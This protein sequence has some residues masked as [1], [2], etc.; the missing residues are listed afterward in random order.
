MSS[1]PHE[2]RLRTFIAA[3][4]ALAIALI[5]PGAV[6]AQ[7]CPNP[8]TINSA[9]IEFVDAAS[10]A[11][12]LEGKGV[13]STA[14]GTVLRGKDMVTVELDYFQP[15][16]SVRAV[17]CPNPR[18]EGTE[19]IPNAARGV[20]RLL[21]ERASEPP[22]PPAPR[23]EGVIREFL[24]V[25][26]IYQGG[27]LVGETTVLVTLEA[28][29]VDAEGQPISF[30]D[31]AV[32]DRIVAEG[33]RLD[34]VAESPF[35]GIAT[36]E[37]DFVKRLS[38]VPPPPPPPVEKR[39]TIVEIAEGGCFALTGEF[40]DD[41]TKVC[42]SNTTVIRTVDGVPLGFGDLAVEDFVTVAGV[43]TED[44]VLAAR[45]VIRAEREPQEIVVE[46]PIEGI[47]EAG[48]PWIGTL[49]VEGRTILVSEG[50]EIREREGA[51]LT[52]ADLGEGDMV[53][54][55]A[56]RLPN[57]PP[58]S[59]EEPT[60]EIA[61]PNELFAATSIVRLGEVPPTPT[62]TPTPVPTE[63]VTPTPTRTPQPPEALTG[64]LREIDAESRCFT[65]VTDRITVVQ[66]TRVCTT[67]TTQFIGADETAIRF[68]DLNEGD[69]V[70]VSLVPSPDNSTPA[71]AAVVRVVDPN[72][73]RVEVRGP[74]RSIEPGPTGS[75]GVV[76]VRETPFI[77][78][79]AT[80]LID[81]EGEPIRFEQLAV[82][83]FV[84]AVGSRTFTDVAVVAEKIRLLPDPEVVPVTLR[85][86]IEEVSVERS[87]LIVRGTLVTVGPDTRILERENEALTL[88]D[89]AT[90]DQVIVEGVRAS[91]NTVAAKTI[92]R[93]NPVVEEPVVRFSDKIT[94][95]D[96]E[97]AVLVVGAR[98]VQ[99]NGE[100]EILNRAGEAMEFADLEV[101]QLVAVV[102]TPLQGAE[103]G[104]P[105]VVLASSIRIVAP[106]C[107]EFRIAGILNEKTEDAWL[108]GDKRVRITEDTTFSAGE[109]IRLNADDFEI[110][111]RVVAFGC[112]TPGEIP[113][114][115]HIVLQNPNP[116]PEPTVCESTVAFAGPVESIDV[117]AASLVVGERT[118]QVNDDTI[119]TK[120]ED[121][122]IRL[123]DIPVGA[124]AFVEGNP[125]ED[126]VVA[127][128][129][130][131]EDR[132][133]P[134]RPEEHRIVGRIDTI[135]T[136]SLTLTVRDFTI[137]VT[138]ETRIVSRSNDEL[139]FGDLS[140]GMLIDAKGRLFPDRMLV[141]GIIRVQEENTT[142][143]PMRPFVGE[144]EEIALPESLVVR[145]ITVNLTNETRFRGF[146][147]EVL[148]PTTLVIGD[149]VMVFPVVPGLDR[150][151]RI[152]TA[153]AIALR[154]VIIEAI[155]AENRWITV[156]GSPVAVV[157]ETEIVD[158][159]SGPITFED[160]AVGDVVRV[161]KFDTE[162]FP[163]HASHILRV[164]G[165][166]FSDPVGDMDGVDGDVEDGRPTFG[167]DRPGN[168]F[169]FVSLPLDMG[170]AEPNTLYEILMNV[171]TNITDPLRI[172]AA[173]VRVNMRN[174][175]KGATAVV[176]S[177]A[178]FSHVPDTR[179]RTYSLLFVPPAEIISDDPED[180]HFFVSLDMLNF[181][182]R[183]A[184]GARFRLESV[185]VDPIDNSRISV[186]ETLAEDTFVS[187]TEGWELGGVDGVFTLPEYGA[188]SGALTLSAR[189]RSTFGYWTKDTGATAEPGK[190]YRARFL[191]H[192][193]LDDAA[194]LPT[195]RLRLN[196]SS[197]ELGSTVN[198][199]PAGP[200][201]ET[202]STDPRVYDVYMVIPANDPGTATIRAS[203]DI[204]CF[205]P[206]NSTDA[207]ITIERFILEEVEI[208]D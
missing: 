65:V 76:T 122:R 182:D 189:D 186:V 187:G 46:G 16:M 202:L 17:F 208:T 57:P 73:G 109:D 13:F 75:A 169:G 72:V 178:T 158:R 93:R 2:P 88:A 200:R 151:E 117:D 22:P 145:G 92:I 139:G 44:G 207:E 59:P 100:T 170:A 119:I 115:R 205:N 66:A 42:T 32:G 113:A 58:P 147:D 86:E 159:R 98:V 85:G 11:V 190:T 14:P 194:A 90:G 112:G 78:T 83:Q 7:E 23:V 41:I 103:R 20:L 24:V 135:D 62:A 128:R 148:D 101:G 181:E 68:E 3:L 176:N 1:A 142:P 48:G 152:V 45:L 84:H 124:I 134:P 25:P 34:F 99:T 168:A 87:Q 55:T 114:A 71:I 69:R 94:E 89:L 146:G 47:G 107:I 40:T 195:F 121:G 180:A 108:I 131:I 31:L 116:D 27:F 204:L 164:S 191:L 193:N 154:G 125:A 43:Y 138:E 197:F 50:T 91:N 56:T 130:R 144:I 196:T 18:P 156:Q 136:A 39:G 150:D 54:I 82:G 52:F 149:R 166:E 129:I 137:K 118:V 172:P 111:D 198:I 67:N 123:A 163:P 15:G 201:R 6:P 160:L 183:F 49:F 10:G 36:L 206:E 30:V 161:R 64:V 179:G 81:A 141:A 77:V 174:F 4:M 177:A 8:E 60:E 102:G 96:P 173:R 37:A 97:S 133:E 143:R 185:S 28:R 33:A 104:R 162:P 61:V 53:R 165:V 5:L 79:N 199:D 192:T 132:P 19:G 106:A 80:E 12:A 74:I 110:G 26:A 126:A 140:R 167:T 63:T 184:R 171:S 9:T 157:D 188:A 105:A 35:P 155:D 70:L 21:Q 203:L 153:R 175:E 120:R 38:N 51:E 127:C 95:I 29:V